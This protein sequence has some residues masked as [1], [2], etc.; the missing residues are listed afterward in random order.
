MVNAVVRRVPKNYPEARRFLEE[1]LAIY[2]ELGDRWGITRTLNAWGHAASE[3]GR[4]PED[5]IHRLQALKLAKE[6][7]NP[8]EIAWALGNLGRIARAQGEY[9]RARHFFE[10]GLAAA[11]GIGGGIAIGVPLRNGLGNVALA[12][13]RYGEARRH[14]REA[15]A[16]ARG[17][18]LSIGIV[19]SLSH[20]GYVALAMREAPEAKQL[21]CQALQIA[22]ERQLWEQSSLEA[23]IGLARLQARSGN[24]ERALELVVLVTRQRAYRPETSD[25]AKRLLAELQ[26]ELPADIYAAAKE[27]GRTQDLEATVAEL[28][29]DLVGS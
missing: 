17:V 12:L 3:F 23:L 21:F 20:L 11:K 27:R 22:A 16:V 5:E 14:Y 2:R 1:S 25:K 10:Q 6:I 29:A 9:A 8:M 24:R 15:L 7:D 28:L 13:G 19:D 18:G 4:Y 26:A